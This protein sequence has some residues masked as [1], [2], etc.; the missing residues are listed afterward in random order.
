M[1]HDKKNLSS[2]KVNCTLLQ[3][4]GNARIDRQCDDQLI[5]EALDWL[6]SL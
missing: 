3:V 5:L 4:V 6:F 1:H 2:D